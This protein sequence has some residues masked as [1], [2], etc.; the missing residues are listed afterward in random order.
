[1]IDTWESFFTA[2]EAMRT[3]QKR[4]FAT[5][6]PFALKEA[7]AIELEVDRFIKDR[8]EKEASKQPELI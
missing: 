7:K 1:M 3:E 5:K 2:V 4:F 8:R 6:S